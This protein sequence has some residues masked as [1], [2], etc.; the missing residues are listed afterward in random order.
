LEKKEK[1]RK[2]KEKQKKDKEKEENDSE[3]KEKERD[4]A[5]KDRKRVSWF[6]SFVRSYRKTKICLFLISLFNLGWHFITKLN[7]VRPPTSVP[8]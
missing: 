3:E 8:E 5:K 1:L 4:V 2:E 6:S 7:F